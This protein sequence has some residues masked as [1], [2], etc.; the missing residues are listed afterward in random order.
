MSQKEKVHVGLFGG[1]SVYTSYLPEPAKHHVV[2]SQQLKSL[3]PS[4]S[5]EVYNLA[6]NGE[7]IARYLLRETYERHRDLVPGLDVAI[8]RFGTNDQ[9]RMEVSEYRRHFV[10]FLDLLMEDFPGVAVFL[11]TGIYLDFPKHYDFNRNAVLNPYW[12]IA[13]EI[14]S[15]RGWPLID[16][17]QRIQTEAEQ[18]NWD[19]RVRK[20]LIPDASQDQGK[21]NDPSWFTDIHP[22]PNGVRLAVDEEVSII[23]S[24]FPEALPSGQKKAERQPRRGEEY[25][26]Y[27]G[28][29]FARLEVSRSLNPETSLQ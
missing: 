14:A 7:F 13:R 5:L 1:S 17:Y 21:E 16:Y 26:E 20:G 3:Y 11:E 8:I 22:N 2:L 4:Q 28:F 15:Q 29:P 27:L 19:V 23:R 25:S 12:D 6:D 10:R 24:S 18:G 9:K